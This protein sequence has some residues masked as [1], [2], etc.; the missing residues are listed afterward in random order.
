MLRHEDLQGS[1]DPFQEPLGVGAFEAEPI[2]L[3][4]SREGK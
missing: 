4:P 3:D 1:P 2:L